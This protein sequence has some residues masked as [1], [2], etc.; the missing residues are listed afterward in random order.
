VIFDD[1]SFGN[2]IFDDV[3]FDDVIFDELS[4]PLSIALKLPV[5]MFL[6]I[7]V[8]SLMPFYKGR[9]FIL[10]TSKCLKEKSFKIGTKMN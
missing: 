3:I 1:V 4:D 7:L 8:D 10:L 6:N 9:K 2:V 5:R